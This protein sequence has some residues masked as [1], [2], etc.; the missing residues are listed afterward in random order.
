MTECDD[1]AVYFHTP[2]GASPTVDAGL[3]CLH[4]AGGSCV[5]SGPQSDRSAPS[6]KAPA[7]RCRGPDPSYPTAT[8]ATPV[9]S[10]AYSGSGPLSLDLWDPCRGINPFQLPNPLFAP[11]GTLNRPLNPDPA[12]LLST[13]TVF[14][15]MTVS[16]NGQYAGVA[17]VTASMLP[18]AAAMIAEFDLPTASAAAPLGNRPT[19]KNPPFTYLYYHPIHGLAD[20]LGLYDETPPESNVNGTPK[21]CFR[22]SQSI[23]GNFWGFSWKAPMQLCDPQLVRPVIT[24]PREG[25]PQLLSPVVVAGNANPRAEVRIWKGE[26]LQG[27]TIA[28][29]NGNF[30]LP[31]HFANGTHAITATQTDAYGRTSP[32]TS[33]SFTL[34]A[35]GAD[36]PP[37]ATLLPFYHLYKLYHVYTVDE[38]E[39]AARTSTDT[40]LG[41]WTLGG[42]VGKCYSSEVAGTTPLYR[43]TNGSDS[44]DRFYTRDPAE[45]NVARAA[46]WQWEGIPWQG[47][48]VACWVFASQVAGTTPLYR[49][50]LNAPFVYHFYTIDKA[51]RDRL[52][53]SGQ[54]LDELIE[55]YLV[56]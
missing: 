39:R 42:K 44:S 7:D 22:V 33:T 34:T 30:T 15:T 2:K 13:A 46:G 36:A 26:Y 18:T 27:S 10:S 51:L 14:G 1:I 41:G 53:A 43:L 11:G 28:D 29:A 49:L 54:W 37:T 6:D 38:E 5:T 52:I 9:T 16:T 17:A 47:M 56:M 35:L 24:A 21:P 3:V 48:G 50:Q 55:G 32:P 12:T 4:G 40:A 8:A 23:R 19:H 20:L 45:A 31:I 25:D